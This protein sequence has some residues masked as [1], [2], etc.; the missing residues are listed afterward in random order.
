[1]FHNQISILYFLLGRHSTLAI[2]RRKSV[3]INKHRVTSNRRIHVAGR[4][5]RMSKSLKSIIGDIFTN[6]CWIVLF[7]KKERLSRHRFEAIPNR[8]LGNF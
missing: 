7:L 6:L 8:A 5:L 1:M 2:E 3:V 4:K